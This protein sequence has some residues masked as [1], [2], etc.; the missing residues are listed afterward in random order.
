VQFTAK[1]Y[2]ESE[3]LCGSATSEQLSIPIDADQLTVPEQAIKENLIPL[4]ASTRY[5][6]QNSLTWDAGEKRHV[7]ASARPSATLTS[8]NPSNIGN[9][10]GALGQITFN[11]PTISSTPSRPLAR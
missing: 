9:N 7:W 4:D 2:S 1:F 6:Y 10:I 3:W 11:Q 8:L 5:L